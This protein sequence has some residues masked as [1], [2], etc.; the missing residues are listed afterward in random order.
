MIKI[1]EM[2]ITMFYIFCGVVVGS[3][4]LYL[5]SRLISYAA[6]KSWIQ[7][8]TNQQT[9]QNGGVNNGKEE[10]EEKFIGPE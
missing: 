6:A 8:T 10:K 1:I 5:I 7:V 2:L 3:V 4:L 9:K